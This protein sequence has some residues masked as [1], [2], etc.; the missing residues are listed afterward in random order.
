MSNTG[1][2]KL[3]RQLLDWEWFDNP[4]MVKV[5]VYFLLKA[6]YKDCSWQGITIPRGSFI[7]SLDTISKDCKMSVREVRT[8]L[9]R[10]KLTGELTIK[11]T[12]RYSMV[13]ICKYDDY[14]SV[15]S[16]IDKQTDKPTDNQ[17]T[18]QRQT[19]DKQTT[20]D[21]EYNNINNRKKK[22]EIKEDSSLCEKFPFDSW[23]D[24]YQ[25]KRNRDACEKKWSKL[26]DA[27]KEAIMEHTPKYVESTPDKQ[28]RKDPLSYLNQHTWN[29]EIIKRQQTNTSLDSGA[30]VD[31][32]GYIPGRYNLSDEEKNKWND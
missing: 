22:K 1:Y 29:D 23:W 28:Y 5:W 32:P 2:I 10:L 4:N 7:T 21:K 15:D 25:K 6:K 9:N 11:T 12:N 19:N 3:H 14:N 20:T 13:T 8:C 17:E 16:E 30:P 18:S 31:Y 24:S 26:S 27:D